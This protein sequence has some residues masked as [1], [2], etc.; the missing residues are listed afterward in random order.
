M[1]KETKIDFIEAFC[2]EGKGDFGKNDDSVSDT[3]VT[4][5]VA[6]NHIWKGRETRWV[7]RKLITA[8]NKQTQSH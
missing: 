6:I 7:D 1:C 8:L 3:T 2:Q 5:F 4:E